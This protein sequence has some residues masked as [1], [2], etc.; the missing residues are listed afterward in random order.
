MTEQAERARRFLELHQRG[1]PLLLPNAWDVGSAR[2]FKSLGVA[3]LATTSSGHAA[4]LGRRDGEVTRDEAIA[5]AA[6][7]TEATGLPVT[8][9][10]E[11]CFAREPAG[12]AET[13]RRAIDAGIAGCSVED[14]TRDDADPIYELGPATER[15]AAAAE[16][17][18]ASGAPFVLTGRCDNHLR[19]RGDLD[20]TIAR[21]RSYQEAGADVLYAPGLKRIEELRTVIASVDRPVN[22]LFVPG[23]P[24]V[25]EL[26][27]AGAARI[28]VGGG[29][30][31][32]A[33]G[34]AVRAARELLESGTYSLAELRRAGIDAVDAAVDP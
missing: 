27:A 16:A 2:L 31:F 8:G 22:V 11:D 14:Y 33:Y 13:V 1:N 30:A 18:R 7:L 34:A 9:D 24:P 15:V 4:S 19:D 12:V 6:E 3:A 29:F 28:S 21:L 32:L 23:A 5:H 20:D 25:A 26:A 10:F 17:V